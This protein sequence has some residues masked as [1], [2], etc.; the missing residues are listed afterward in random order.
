MAAARETIHL[1]AHQGSRYD[2]LLFV[3]DNVLIGPDGQIVVADKT[4]S[5]SHLELKVDDVQPADCVSALL[6]SV[7]LHAHILAGK[8]QVAIMPHIN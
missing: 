5:R 6:C 3:L 4:I 8:S 1:R 2:K 7:T